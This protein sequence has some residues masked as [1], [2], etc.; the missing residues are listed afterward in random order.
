MIKRTIQ[1]NPN[2]KKK[3]GYKNHFEDLVKRAKNDINVCKEAANGSITFIAENKKE[4][5]I[6]R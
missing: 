1:K 5:L 3:K 6:L 2:L 4:S